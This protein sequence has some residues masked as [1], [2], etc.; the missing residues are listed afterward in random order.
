MF[1]T[2]FVVFNEMGA[3]PWPGHDW[4]FLWASVICQV[5]TGCWATGINMLME[6]TLPQG[7]TL[8]KQ[9]HKISLMSGGKAKSNDGGRLSEWVTWELRLEGCVETGAKAGKCKSSC[10]GAGAEGKPADCTV[11]GTWRG[12]RSRQQLHPACPLEHFKDFCFTGIKTGS[13]LVVLN[14]E[15]T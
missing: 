8:Y 2:L 15:M 14:R 9:S 6:P 4:L 3:Q 10:N 11:D 5:S 12:W 13:H 1:G 7:V